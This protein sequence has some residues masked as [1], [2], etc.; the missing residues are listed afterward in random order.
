MRRLVPATLLCVGALALMTDPADAAAPP[1]GR[2]NA[3]VNA[4]IV[5]I[6]TDIRAAIGHA[7]TRTDAQLAKE[8]A[9]L[10]TRTSAASIKVAKL[11]GATGATA[12]T[13]RK[14]QLA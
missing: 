6:G 11:Q 7:G 13:Q 12:T 4:Q 10:A 3:P 9:G 2:A 1:L 5:K 14:L 8:F